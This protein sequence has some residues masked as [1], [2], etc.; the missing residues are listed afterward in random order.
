MS[1]KM[2][3][4]RGDDVV[5][6]SGDG[7]RLR[8]WELS[9]GTGNL[10]VERADRRNLR[11]VGIERQERQARSLHKV[12]VRDATR[13]ASLGP[14]EVEGAQQQ[15]VAAVAPVEKR[16]GKGETRRR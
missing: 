12:Q 8:L 9:H 6:M 3:S 14:V 15:Y 16:V 4:G 7:R 10:K 5:V 13:R 11:L 2:M 1:S